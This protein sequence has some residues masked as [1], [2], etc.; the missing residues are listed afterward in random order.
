[1]LLLQF[2][3]DLTDEEVGEVLFGCKNVAEKI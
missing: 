3:G 2:L 1:M